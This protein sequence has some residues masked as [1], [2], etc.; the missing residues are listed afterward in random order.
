MAEIK[1][2]KSYTADIGGVR[3]GA[4]APVVASAACAPRTM[5]TRPSAT[6]TL[7]SASCLRKPAVGAS[8]ASTASPAP[9]YNFAH[10]PTITSLEQHW[11]DKESGKAWKQP[12]RYEDI[13]MPRNTASGFIVSCFGLLLSFAG[14]SEDDLHNAARK[15]IEVMR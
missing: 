8:P 1:R 5:K 14:F 12:D 10:V 4:D 11:D 3:V 9:F 7:P 13:H 15:L 6:R 2:R